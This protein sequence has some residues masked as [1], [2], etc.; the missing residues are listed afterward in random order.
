MIRKPS[1]LITG[2]ASGI[3]AATAV[4]LAKEGWN[5]A[6]HTNQN[7]QGLFDVINAC[8]VLG[9]KCI[10][11][12]KSFGKLKQVDEFATD[13]LDNISKAFGTLDA[14]IINAGYASNWHWDKVEEEA[15]CETFSVH[16][17]QLLSLALHSKDSL[18]QSK[19]ARIVVIGS[20][21]TLPGTKQG[22]RF[23]ISTAAKSAQENFAKS[24]ALEFANI[25]CTVNVIHPGY[26]EKDQN[27][28]SPLS[29]EEWQQV[30]KNIPLK[31][32]GTPDDIAA[33]IKFLVSKNA[34]YITGQSFSVDGG[35]T[36]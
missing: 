31:R 21:T 14:L 23:A 24:L 22:K 15:I 30:V 26:I 29:D 36:L 8:S 3:G 12:T 19:R 33:C 34:S 20:F 16:F 7:S 6:L 13:I 32:L 4:T 18:K 5:I 9:A 11:S 1:V 25:N 2:A 28:T 17:G 27:S 10:S 35:L